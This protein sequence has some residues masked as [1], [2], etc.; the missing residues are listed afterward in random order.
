VRTAIR[1]RL[2]Y[3]RLSDEDVSEVERLM[4]EAPDLQDRSLGTPKVALKRMLIL[5][6]GMCTS[7]SSTI[8]E[9]GLRPDQP[10]PDV[11]TMAR[12]PVLERV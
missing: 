2:L 6:F 11:N 3:E 4:K 1:Q 5:H 9:T 8:E 12:G 10:R 7:L